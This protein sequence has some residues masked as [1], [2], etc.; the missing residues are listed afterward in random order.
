[1]FYLRINVNETPEYQKISANQKLKFPLFS[2]LKEIPL[3]VVGVIGLAWLVS[4]MTFGTYVFAATYLYTYFN[5]S[6]SLATLIVTLSLTV[7]ALL[8]PLVAFL[9][10]KFGSLPIIKFGMMA[11]FFL[12]TPIFHLI[13]TRSVNL[14]I[15]GMVLMSVLI[16]ITYA[17]LNAYMVSL[18]PPQYRYSGFSVSFNT[19]ISIF[20][21]TA[22][23]V[24]MWLIQKTGN[25]MAP[26]WCYMIGAM[27]GLVSL[28]M[29]EYSRK[30]IQAYSILSL[31]DV[32][33]DVI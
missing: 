10:D 13:L 30:G 23:L 9:A 11:L 28:M 24:M 7:D 2:V 8:E 25:L 15:I 12:S 31:S 21:G 6:L 17:S 27:I 18:F 1:M 22:P 14:I 32:A 16:A 4:I 3:T 5:I 29:C 26:S 33:E 20:G 19:G